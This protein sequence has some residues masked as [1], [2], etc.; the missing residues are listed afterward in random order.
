MPACQ[1]DKGAAGEQVQQRVEL[2]QPREEQEQLRVEL[3]Q[4]RVELVQP[5]VVQI[6][7]HPNNRI[8]QSKNHNIP[9]LWY[10]DLCHY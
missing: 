5:R 6:M 7:T 4:Q 9:S 3:V 10:R 2:V 8:L 1:G